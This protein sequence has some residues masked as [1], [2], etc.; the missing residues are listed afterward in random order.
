MSSEAVAFNTLPV[1]ESV[2]IGPEDPLGTVIPTIVAT[3]PDEDEVTFVYSWVVDGTSVSTAPTL[4]SDL[5]GKGDSIKL[6]VTPFDGLHL[7][8]FVN[9]NVIHGGNHPRSSRRCS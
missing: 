7:G 8:A 4:T 5:Y 9:S 2:V 3:D 1:I 6:K